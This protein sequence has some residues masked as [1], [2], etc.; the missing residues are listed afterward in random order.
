MFLG[1]LDSNE[2]ELFLNLVVNAAEVDSEFSNK[3]KEQI[4]AYVLEMGLTLKERHAYVLENKD[5]FSRLSASSEIVRRS[6]FMELTAL[7]MADG[8]HKNEEALLD[9]AQKAFK[10]SNSYREEVICWYQEMTPLYKK[11]FKLAGFGGL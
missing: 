10:L 1:T 3:E 2:K 5:I 6:I 8:M 9:E 11:G 4:E 7:M